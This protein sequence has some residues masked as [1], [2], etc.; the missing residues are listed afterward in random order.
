MMG[1]LTMT[2]Q[3]APERDT[4]DM[5]RMTRTRPVRQAG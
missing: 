2:Q 4:A 3:T 1:N 5:I